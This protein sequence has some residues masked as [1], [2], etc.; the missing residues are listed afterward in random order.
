MGLMSKIN[1]E[2]LRPFLVKICNNYQ[3]VPYHNFTHAF[4]LTY[5]AYWILQHI[6]KEKFFTENEVLAI[7]L[8][9]IGHDWNH[10]GLNNGYMCKTRHDIAIL[11]NDIS[12]LENMHCTILFQVMDILPEENY[13][14]IRETIIESI[15]CT[16]M[17]KHNSLVDK[18]KALR[19]KCKDDPEYKFEKADRIFLCAMIVHACDLSNCVLEYEHCYKWSIRIAQEFH[20]QYKAEEKLDAD[21][22]G[23]PTAFLKYTDAAGFG[24]SQVGFMDFVLKPMWEVLWDILK[25][26]TVVLDNLEENKKKLLTNLT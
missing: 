5:V 19:D 14:D 16:D 20:D 25:L 24:K 26:D 13:K 2:K 21:K 15:I 22:Y 18:L 4:T 6:D 11:Y 3:M 7:I 23:P 10:P 8:A 12:V 9:C 17:S 1:E